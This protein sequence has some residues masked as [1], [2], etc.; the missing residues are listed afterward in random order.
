MTK[1]QQDRDEQYLVA[2]A[3]RSD[4]DRKQAQHRRDVDRLVA[5][6]LLREDAR[7]EWFAARQQSA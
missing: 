6:A 2:R 1:Q 7:R 5:D 4:A 3:L